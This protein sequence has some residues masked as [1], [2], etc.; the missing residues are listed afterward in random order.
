[1]K[2]PLR[3]R[4]AIRYRQLS[5]PGPEGPGLYQITGLPSSSIFYLLSFYVFLAVYAALENLKSRLFGSFSAHFCT[6]I[7]GV[8]FVPTTSISF[9]TILNFNEHKH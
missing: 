7:F 2:S 5:P 8:T 3:C 9:F 1:M 6:F 4:P